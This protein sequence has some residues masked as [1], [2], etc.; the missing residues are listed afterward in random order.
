MYQV[1]EHLSAIR[2]LL[3]TPLCWTQG[4]EARD[5]FGG[6]CIPSS[7]YATCWCLVGATRRIA[8][9]PQSQRAMEVAIMRALPP[10][11]RDIEDYNDRRTRSHGEVL[12]LIERAICRAEQDAAEQEHAALMAAP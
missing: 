4:T 9:D 5:M 11:M 3:K 12:A 8:P 2:A 6:H 1:I 7:P 10:G